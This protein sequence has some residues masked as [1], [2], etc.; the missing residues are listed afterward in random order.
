MNLKKY[1]LV[2]AFFLII[3]L[4]SASYYVTNPGSGSLGR[5]LNTNQGSFFVDNNY[6]LSGG[7]DRSMCKEGQDFVLFVDPLSCSPSVVRS[8][9]LEEQDVPVICEIK[10]LKINPMADIDLIRNVNFMGD[11]SSEI[12]SV[13]FH[14]VYSALGP[15]YNLNNLQTDS[16]GNV[17]LV[18]RQNPNESSMPDFVEANLTAKISYDVNKAIGVRNPQF[19]LPVMGDS[20]FDERQGQYPFLKNRGYLR[21]DAI[22]DD[23]AVISVYSSFYEGTFGKSRE[24]EISKQKLSSYELKKGESTP[25]FYLPGYD[26]YAGAR[27]ILD[28]LVVPD[29]TAKIVVGSET[30]ELRRN[31]R[32]LD[33]KCSIISLEELGVSQTVKIN[34]EVDEGDRNFELV[35]SPNVELE[36]DGSLGNYSLGDYLYTLNENTNEEERVYLGFVSSKEGN[37][38]EVVDLKVHL[39]SL[40]DHQGRTKLSNEQIRQM[41]YFARVAESEGD[42]WLS[43]GESILTL[44]TKLSNGVLKGNF[45]KSVEEGEATTFQDKEVRFIGLSGSVNEQLEKQVQAYYENAEKDYLTVLNQYPEEEFNLDGSGLIN[46]ARESYSKRIELASVLGQKRFALELCEEFEENY[47]G[48]EFPEVCNNRGALYGDSMAYQTKLIEGQLVPFYLKSVSNPGIEEY[49]AKISVRSKDGKME[50]HLLVKDRISYIENIN[51][52]ADYIQLAELDDNFAKIKISYYDSQGEKRVTET[53]TLNKGRSESFGTDYVFNLEEINLKKQAKVR[54]EIKSQ[55]VGS[56]GNFSV[57]V[58]IDKRLI[59]LTPEK[60]QERIDKLD[61]SIEDFNQIVNTISTVEQGLR[62]TCI[63][64]GGYLTLKNL[65]GGMGGTAI[66]RKEVMTGT[67]GWN[68]QCKNALNEKNADGKPIYSSFEDCLFKN[69]KK[70]DEEVKKVEGLMDEQNERFK[71]IYSD[72]G[73]LSE[74]IFENQVMNRTKVAEIYSGDVKSELDQLKNLEFVDEEGKF[75]DSKDESKYVNLENLKTILN[76]EGFESGMYSLD[77]IKRIELYSKLVLEEPNNAA[78]RERLYDSLKG[79][80]TVSE[81]YAKRANLADEHKLKVHEIAYLMMNRGDSP[82]VDG[83]RTVKYYGTTYRNTNLMSLGSGKE[84]NPVQIVQGSN[85]E[86]YVVELNDELGTEYLTIKR[87]EKDEL[88]IYDLGVRDSSEIIQDKNV[89]NEFRKLTFMRTERSVYNNPLNMKEAK[90]SYYETEPYKGLPALVP[91]DSKNGWYAYI[92]Q[93]MPSYGKQNSYS[94]SGRVESFWICNAGS[95][96]LMDLPSSGQD[97]C[98][99]IILGIRQTTESFLGL[100]QTESARVLRNAQNSIE[101]AQRGYKAGVNRVTILGETFEVGSPEYSLGGFQCTD[102]MSPQ[103]C[104]ILFNVCDPVICPSSRCD[105]G[106]KYPVRDVIQS[107]VVGSIA[108]CLPNYQE[109]IYVPVCISGV[110]AGLEGFNSVLESYRDCLQTSLDTGQTVGICDEINSIYVCEFFWKQAIPLVKFGVP[111]LL[112]LAK[113]EVTRG[114]GEYLG[115]T[116]AWENA[117]SSID[118]FTDYYAANSWNAF[119]ARSTEEVGGE[120][121]KVFGSISYPKGQGVFDLLLKG[122]SPAQFNGNFQEIP[123]TSQTNPPF[124]HYK[125]YFHIYAGDDRPAY[126][127]VYLRG[128]SSSYYQDTLI[129]RTVDSD[130]ISQ[131]GYASE[132]IDFTAPSGYTELCIRVNEYEECGFGR[133]G[134]SFAYDYMA[135][136]Y[137][138]RQANQTEITTEKACISGT[139]D[140][141]SLFN[142]NAQAAAENMID[143]EIYNKGVI[144]VCATENPGQGVSSA[145]AGTINSRWK[146]VGN[147]GDENIRCWIDTQSLSKAFEWEYSYDQTMDSLD[148]HYLDKLVSSGEG[149][150]REQFEEILEKLADKDLSLEEKIKLID[151]IINIVVYPNQKAY[152][153]HM[154]G[155]YYGELAIQN[156]VK[157]S[158]EVF[159]KVFGISSQPIEFEV[160]DNSESSSEEIDLTVDVVKSM[161]SGSYRGISVNG[162]SLILTSRATVY[163]TN[164]VYGMDYTIFSDKRIDDS[165]RFGGD[166]DFRFIKN[167]EGEEVLALFE[168]PTSY[169][170]FNSMRYSDSLENGQEVIVVGYSFEKSSLENFSGKIIGLSNQEI[171]IDVPF[172]KT[173]SRGALVLD[174]KENVLG[175][176]YDGRGDSSSALRMSYINSQ[177]E[178][179]ILSDGTP[180]EMKA[181]EEDLIMDYFIDKNFI[182]PIIK[183]NRGTFSSNVCYQF[184]QGRWWWTNDCGSAERG[185]VI[186]SY[187]GGSP[188][189]TGQSGPV[190]SEVNW[191]GSEDLNSKKID[192]ENYAIYNAL[193]DITSYEEGVRLLLEKVSLKS[194]Y[195]ISVGDV[196]VNNERVFDLGIFEEDLYMHYNKD[197]RWY[198]SLISKNK[199]D[200]DK[201]VDNLEKTIQLNARRGSIISRVTGSYTTYENLSLSDDQKKLFKLISE[202]TDSEVEGAMILFS[203]NEFKSALSNSIQPSNP[204]LVQEIQQMDSIQLQA[205]VEELGEKTILSEQELDFIRERDYSKDLIIE[206]VKNLPYIRIES[207]ESVR[208][209]DRH[210]TVE[211]VLLPSQERVLNTLNSWNG[212]IVPKIECES[213]D[214]N[215]FHC[216]SSMIFLYNEARV[217]HRC[218]YSDEG[219]K[220]YS[221]GDSTFV[222][223]DA[224]IAIGKF[225]ANPDSCQNAGGYVNYGEQGKLN[226]LEPG[227]L[228]DLV[229]GDLKSAHTIV[230]VDWVDK[231]SGLARAYDWNGPMVN[232]AEGSSR[233]DI[234][235]SENFRSSNDRRCKTYRYFE[236]NLKDSDNPIYLIRKPF[237]SEDDS[238]SEDDG[239]LVQY[240]GIRINREQF[241]VLR[242]ILIMSDIMVNDLNFADSLEDAEGKNSVG[243]DDRGR[244]TY[245]NLT[246]IGLDSLE[247]FDKLENL[248]FLYLDSNYLKDISELNNLRSLEAV[249]VRNNCIPSDYDYGYLLD[250]LGEDSFL[251]SGNPR[252]DCPQENNFISDLSSIGSGD[253]TRAISFMTTY[254]LQGKYSDNEN[255]S[256]FV[257][258]L[259]EVEIINDEEYQDING[260][261][262]LWITWGGSKDMSYVRNLLES[263]ITPA[264]SEEGFIPSSRD[265]SAEEV[266]LYGDYHES[267]DSNID[268][269]EYDEVILAFSKANK[270]S[271]EFLKALIY[272]ES[273]FDPDAVS[274]SGCVGLMQFCPST[275]YDYGLCDK[276]DCSGVDKRNDSVESIAAGSKYVAYLFEF[277]SG[278]PADFNHEMIVA[279]AYNVGPRIISESIS[280]LEDQVSDPEDYRFPIWDAWDEPSVSDML[281]TKISSSKFREVEIHVERVRA[282]TAYY[283]Y[284]CFAN[285]NCIA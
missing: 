162:K 48:T 64:T 148:E 192:D 4:V 213:L 28:D 221:V 135:D 21:A 72:E 89:I 155:N 40:A 183:F 209:A 226:I 198:W 23:S 172:S 108:L 129:G 191:F 282:A 241:E 238:F 215:G 43:K 87:N 19:Y 133:A 61:N 204:E 153:H 240:T 70:I 120:F 30:V 270:I 152:L 122:D 211:G 25:L 18:L 253:Y 250:K 6:D 154:R 268:N 76:G 110:R 9:L 88:L 63:A 60:T 2:F 166:Y 275:A 277:L 41:S 101:Q 201:W 158:K 59:Q 7:F 146:D 57:R 103:D 207:L 261:Q 161:S 165:V 225:N 285:G 1:F 112:S 67:G 194:S 100:D 121:C 126:Y 119:K 174:V 54:V 10:A 137:I 233:G 11:W 205:L 188:G 178:G 234:C 8:D 228:V 177:V 140:F 44:M 243:V 29:T 276:V 223:S 141:Y 164:G 258:R 13:G 131:G 157:E 251:Y 163:E 82:D 283:T 218:V 180:G 245:L 244:I 269:T 47:P 175:A 96:G 284:V 156:N 278:S 84:N 216:Y 102:Y 127:R 86:N 256:L 222:I 50:E 32:F 168:A 220:S 254:N 98:H 15:N 97:N 167:F 271:P 118:Y 53:K 196:K 37:F 34:C 26:C 106:G 203:Y 42:S 111:K 272:V 115:V 138:K 71:E 66:A 202:K 139:T 94:D 104:Q 281:E 232:E 62:A 149:L 217:D 273:G 248:K 187:M 109:G 145:Q 259:R 151:S 147:C 200:L 252:R 75:K 125:V 27:I 199:R 38:G 249:L 69:S 68:E 116:A 280:D 170:N 24:G 124:S 142:L 190:I 39:V 227:Y 78:Y 113:G 229:L 36:I 179:S 85:G 105:F 206:I 114:G 45:Y 65:I 230:F 262:F 22:R 237:S 193:R 210:T 132:T 231:E 92:D 56:T 20:E 176:I 182:S 58:G 107:G 171:L 16:I 134:T 117:K 52:N 99:K 83:S 77:E 33:D 93:N 214:D 247:D 239:S 185:Y 35:L 181:F 195:K 143:P 186:P 189:Y 5:S 265:N 150:S 73:I 219:G 235:S 55:A 17:V 242:E 144:R 257:E 279:A 266:F 81:S 260:V 49:S 91:F 31:E 128:G 246:D 80:E 74:G 3:G 90:V 197:K 184:S 136:Q 123:L 160:E 79:V 264:S 267:F 51:N 255:N 263:K 169:G 236:I 212:R 12:K 46:L 208:G 95:N 159:G 224:N 173:F 130:Y 14:R 274:S